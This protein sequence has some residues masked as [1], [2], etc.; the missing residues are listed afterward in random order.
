MT[1]ANAAPHT[2]YL[3]NVHSS[4]QPLLA[5]GLAKM[6]ASYLSHLERQVNW[7]PGLQNLF[8][9]FSLPLKQTRYVLIGESPYPRPQ[10]AN[11]YAFWDAAVAELWSSTGLAKRVN[12]ATSLR[13][14]I[15]MLLIAEGLLT[16]DTSQAAI[17]A[18]QKAQLVQTNEQLFGNF[19]ENGFLLINATPVLQ[20]NNPPQKDA[21]AWQPFFAYLLFELVK[22]EPTVTFLLF[23]NIANKINILLPYYAKKI[24]ACHPYNIEF[25]QAAHIIDFFKPLHLLK[26]K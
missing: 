15:K 4:W 1:I 5:Q 17:A 20:P 3:N 23:G 9:A 24:T 19:L 25:I 14:L 10:S 13:N 18:V 2:V 21:R 11:G 6:D 22:R 12:R 7:L 26:M 16:N 8:K